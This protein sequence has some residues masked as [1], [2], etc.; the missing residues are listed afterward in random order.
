MALRAQP[1]LCCAVS[2]MRATGAC[3]CTWVQASVPLHHLPSYYV[4]LCA[5]GK[6]GLTW[7]PAALLLHPAPGARLDARACGKPVSRRAKLPGILCTGIR[8][9]CM[10]GSYSFAAF[11]W[12]VGRPL[13]RQDWHAAT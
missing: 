2:A 9:L 1:W 4:P 12:T 6:C 13:L 8:L 5:R 11:G 10:C 7:A 3:A